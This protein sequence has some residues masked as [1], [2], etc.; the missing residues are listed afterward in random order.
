MNPADFPRSGME[1]LTQTDTTQRHEQQLDILVE[2]IQS[3]SACHERNME[4]LCDQL[5]NLTDAARGPDAVVS[6]RSPLHT[7]SGSEACLRP[8]ERCSGTPGSCRPFLVQ[9]SLA[10]EL[11]PSV[12]T[13]EVPGGVHCLSAHGQSQGLGD[14]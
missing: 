4:S 3:M 6:S 13:S 1:P 5:L 12:F 9:C 11:Q 7:A 8:P 14:R 2:A 10:F